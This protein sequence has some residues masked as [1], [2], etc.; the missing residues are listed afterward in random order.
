SLF[1]YECDTAEN[2]FGRDFHHAGPLID[3]NN[4]QNDAIFGDVAA[5]TDDHFLNLFETAFIDQDA[6]YRRFAGDF[7]AGW[8]EADDVSGCRDDHFLLNDRCLYHELRVPVELT[9]GAV[10]GNEILRLHERD[11]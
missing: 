8:S 3:R 10:N 9:V 11:N 4:G 2:D 6:S 5:V 7:R 1:F